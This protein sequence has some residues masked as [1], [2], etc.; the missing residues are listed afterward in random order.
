M[1]QLDNFKFFQENIPWKEVSTH[2][3]DHLIEQRR[4]T[5]LEQGRLDIERMTRI[6]G[7]ES[8][9]SSSSLVIPFSQIRN[10]DET[11]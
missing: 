2:I 6:M 3:L 5:I 1:T 10:T 11:V 4:I 9:F 7:G 8:M